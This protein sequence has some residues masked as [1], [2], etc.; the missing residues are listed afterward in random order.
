MFRNK[1]KT[2][3]PEANKYSTKEL[4]RY[5]DGEVVDAGIVYANK[6]LEKDHIEVNNKKT[7][8]INRFKKIDKDK[9]FT[10]AKRLFWT[11]MILFTAIVLFN[12]I[13][14]IQSEKE[15][16]LNLESSVPNQTQW[17][18]PALDTEGNKNIADNH[19]QEN[20][21]SLEGWTDMISYV[22]QTNQTLIN[23]TESDFDSIH[24][25]QNKDLNR[26]T[27]Q[28][29]L[30]RS[31]SQKEE[32][33]S[34]LIAQKEK[35][36]KQDLD[37]FYEQ[38]LLRANESLSLSKKQVSLAVNYEDQWTTV[39]ESYLGV[40]TAIEAEQRSILIEYLETK[41]IS[42]SIHPSTNEIQF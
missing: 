36:H 16:N 8:L 5:E 15:S 7:S 11:C 34:A 35:F 12:T 30:A 23:I 9:A 18:K 19:T 20:V 14:F 41:E 4:L 13:S 22:K 32:I 28:N 27:L 2:V 6:A 17:T 37:A 33:V 24:S 31:F 25:Y 29:K 21:T 38:T 40:D 1:K 10:Y 39:E 42:Y 3:L 26:K